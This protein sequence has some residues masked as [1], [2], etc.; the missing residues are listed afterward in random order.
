MLKPFEY[1]V[2]LEFCRLISASRVYVERIDG[3][4]VILHVAAFGESAVVQRIGQV[5][6]VCTKFGLI[7]LKFAIGGNRLLEPRGF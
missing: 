6:H 3:G 4:L 1:M 7:V 5:L 2:R